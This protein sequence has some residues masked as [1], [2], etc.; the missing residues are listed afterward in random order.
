MVASR[1]PPYEN[2][3]GLSNNRRLPRGIIDDNWAMPYSALTLNYSDIYSTSVRCPQN[4]IS[5]NPSRS[6]HLFILCYARCFRSWFRTDCQTGGTEL[7]WMESV[8]RSVR[9]P[10]FSFFATSLAENRYMNP[11]PNRVVRK[12]LNDG[13]GEFLGICHFSFAPCAQILFIF[14][15][16]KH[17]PWYG[18]SPRWK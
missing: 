10:C 9:L 16:W 18:V 3:R 11:L 14:L 8:F 12:V 7:S 1:K 5:F 15:S 13:Y 17:W 6:H 4:G 2:H